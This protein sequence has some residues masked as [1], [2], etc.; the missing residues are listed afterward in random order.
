MTVATGLGIGHEPAPELAAQAVSQAMERA[1]IEVAGS[2]LLVLTSEF[3]RDP[4]PALRAAAKA[5]NCTRIIG[6]SA[7][8]IFTEDDWVLDVPAAAAMVFADIIRFESPSPSDANQLLLTLAAP[9]AINTTWMTAPGIRFGGVSGDATGQGPFSVWQH[10]K[11]TV[12][13]HCEMALQGVRGAVAATHGVR[14]LN[15]PRRVTDFQGH[16]LLAL[17][18]R[19][20]LDSLH[21]AREG[22]EHLPM[23]YIVAVFAD[24]VEDIGAGNYQVAPLVSGNED[25]MSVTLTKQLQAGQYLSWA[26]REQ[27]SALTDLQQTAVNLESRLH[28]RPDFAMFFSCLGRGPYFYG[29]VDRDL[30]LLTT[31][32][33][34][35]PI[36][37]FYGNGE[38]APTMR[39][40]RI[41]CELLEY[42][43]VLGLFS[44]G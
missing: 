22:Y 38:I 32:F 8:G 26:V 20:A 34:G 6:C 36:I 42:S 44:R 12:L 25:T 23:H 37:G 2:V 19:S 33:P 9:N 18:G 24:S 28:A 30:G 40:D 1:G 10:G 14:V 13:G 5:A 16:D 39:E 7:T 11:G 21:A 15:M 41:R 35:M 27:E 4:A 31:Q 3:A 43:A 29:G 17:D